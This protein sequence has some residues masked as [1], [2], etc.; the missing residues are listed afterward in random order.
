[1]VLEWVALYA[2]MEKCWVISTSRFTAKVV[3][4]VIVLVISVQKSSN[5]MSGIAINVLKAHGWKAVN[6][7]AFR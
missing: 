4:F 3:H 6:D 2:T 1:M 7:D 5:F